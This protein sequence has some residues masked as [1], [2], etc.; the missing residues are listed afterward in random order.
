MS[1]QACQLIKALLEKVPSKRPDVSAIKSMA[2]FNGMHWVKLL[3][4]EVNPPV[5]PEVA[6]PMDISNIPDKYTKDEVAIDS[7]VSP[8]SL[9]SPT[10]ADL[11]SGFTFDGD[12]GAE[13]LW[14]SNGTPEAGI[15]HQFAESLGERLSQQSSASIS[16]ESTERLSPSRHS[17]ADSDVSGDPGLLAHC[18]L[19][20]PV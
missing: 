13:L 5:R 19:N 14:R 7:P 17:H 15:V 4:L 9:L 3:N 11:F 6:G 1:S 20:C 12:E 8:S 2:F 18:R 10:N 16:D